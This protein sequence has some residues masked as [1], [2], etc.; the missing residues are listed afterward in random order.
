MNVNKDASLES[1]TAEPMKTQNYETSIAQAIFQSMQTDTV[2]DF[3]KYVSENQDVVKAR[4][5]ARGTREKMDGL[6]LKLKNLADDIKAQIIA[7][8]GVA[9]E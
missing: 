3:K 9:T 2:S 4:D 5:N 8:G 1:Q 6:N 7:G